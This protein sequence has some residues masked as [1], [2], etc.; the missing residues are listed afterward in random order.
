MVIHLWDLVR[1]QID[2][3]SSLGFLLVI[4]PALGNGFLWSLDWRHPTIC[5]A[6]RIGHHAMVSK[7]P[8]DRMGGE[9]GLCRTLIF[10]A[11]CAQWAGARNRR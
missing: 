6:T 2:R 4:F 10:S 8:V 5:H 3:L 11:G 9:Y 7:E 1:G